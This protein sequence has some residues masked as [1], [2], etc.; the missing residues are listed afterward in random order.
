VRVRVDLNFRTVSSYVAEFV[1]LLVVP[2]LVG[3]F[4]IVQFVCIL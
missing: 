4:S 1:T 2:C 3:L